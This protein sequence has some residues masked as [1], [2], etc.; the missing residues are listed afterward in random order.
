[1]RYVVCLKVTP[2]TE[3][4]RFDEVKKM[5]AREG[6]ENEINDADKNAIEAALLLKDKHGGSV[7]V[8]TMGPPSFDPFLKLAVAMGA[9]EAILLSD[10]SFAGADTYAT[11]RVLAAAL[12][13]LQGYDLVLCGE[14]SSDGST[15]Q[16]P[17]SIAEWLGIPR[18]T[19]AVDAEVKDS[20]LVSKRSVQGGY[21]V[22]EATLPALVSVELGCNAP[23]FPDFR[24]KRWAENEYKST[25]WGLTDLGFSPGEVGLQGSLTSVE[26]LRKMASPTRKA[27]TVTGTL[28][29]VATKLVQIINASRH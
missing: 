3:Q 9:D 10:R 19:Y 11:S 21:E 16:V 26:E 23:R 5:I 1:M 25:V 18:V 28:R 6:V 20:K 4:I 2:K 29:E 27:E 24:R 12:K 15:E 22:V 13:K 7:T 8:M 17:A 14:A